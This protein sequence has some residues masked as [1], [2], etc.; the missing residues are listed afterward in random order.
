MIVHP[1]CAKVGHRQAPLPSAPQRQSG[2][3]LFVFG[4][5]SIQFFVISVEGEPEKVNGKRNEEEALFELVVAMRRN[6]L[7]RQEKR[8]TRLWLFL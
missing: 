8:W 2:G 1:A 3:G 6:C 4:S 7:M 5:N